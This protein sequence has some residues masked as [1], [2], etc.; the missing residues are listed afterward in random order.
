MPDYLIRLNNSKTLILEVK[1]QD[2][3]QNKAKRVLAVNWVEVEA[4]KKH[5]GF[6]N[7]AF[8]TVA[9]P[10]TVHDSPAAHSFKRET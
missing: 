4:V 2:G 3:D 8:D 9:D 10:S 1:G 5:V 6:G 7:Q